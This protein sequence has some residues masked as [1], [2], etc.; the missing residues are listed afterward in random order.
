M[1]G[2]K[3]RVTKPYL[4]LGQ[5]RFDGGPCLT[6]GSITEQVHDNGTTANSIIDIE[7]VLAGDP[8]ILL[9]FLPRGTIF[10]H[11]NNNV[12]AVV[13]EVK[14]LTVT[15]GTITNESQSVILEKFL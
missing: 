9:G 3:N 8:T 6:L 14:T 7:K 4:S 13:T 15:L 11:T 2:L 12:E 10:P 5:L 1:D